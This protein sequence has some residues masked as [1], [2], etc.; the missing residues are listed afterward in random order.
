MQ[1]KRGPYLID[2]N[3][4]NL[5]ESKRKLEKAKKHIEKLQTMIKKQAPTKKIIKRLVKYNPQIWE[6][7][8]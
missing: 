2:E 5:A 8:R 7:L 4:E 6:A 3:V 1:L